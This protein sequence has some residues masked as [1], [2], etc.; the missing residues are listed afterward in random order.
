MLATNWMQY[1]RAIMHTTHH[2]PCPLLLATALLGMATWAVGVR[3][4]CVSVCGGGITRCSQQRLHENRSEATR[5]NSSHPYSLFQPS[6]PAT[7]RSNWQ[8]WRQPGW[9]LIAPSHVIRRHMY[10][11]HHPCRAASRCCTAQLSCE[12]AMHP[13][14]T[15]ISC[16]QTLL[17][18]NPSLLAAACLILPRL[19]D[20]SDSRILTGGL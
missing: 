18:I 6:S 16:S 8:H 15:V 7:H 4:V 9:P 17:C 19:C 1:R 3:V 5:A 10:H 13:P 11:G 2:V 20:Q 14:L 12:H